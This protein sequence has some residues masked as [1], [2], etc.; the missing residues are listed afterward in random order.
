MLV[1]LQ[2]ISS[3]AL[4]C[5]SDVCLRVSFLTCWRIDREIYISNT[6]EDLVPVKIIS[7]DILV[8]F[9]FILGLGGNANT[10]SD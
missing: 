3:L 1:W 2:I 10:S 4:D 6:G 8:K 9:V 5:P 7:G